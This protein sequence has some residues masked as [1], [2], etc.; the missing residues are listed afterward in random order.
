MDRQDR[1]KTGRAFAGGDPFSRE[2]KAG[3][4]EGE[5]RGRVLSGLILVILPVGEKMGDAS[6]YSLGKPGEV[7]SWRRK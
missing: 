1:G 6:H 3:G 5:A 2:R 4:G 7:E